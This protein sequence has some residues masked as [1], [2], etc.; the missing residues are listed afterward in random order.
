MCLYV[1]KRVGGHLLIQRPL[2]AVGYSAVAVTSH[3]PLHYRLQRFD[4]SNYK[5]NDVIDREAVRSHLYI[6]GFTAKLYSIKKFTLNSMD[7]LR[8]FKKK[9]LLLRIF[10]E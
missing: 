10:K 1:N 2:E 5:S 3:T 7:G 8:G 6:E 9:S 4:S